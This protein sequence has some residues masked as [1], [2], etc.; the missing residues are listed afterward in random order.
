MTTIGVTGHRTFPDAKAVGRGVDRALKKIQKVFAGPFQ[1]CSCLAPGADQMV[2]ERAMYLLKARL[3]VPL[4]L[5]LPEYLLEFAPAPAL[6]LQTLLEQAAEVIH[7]PPQRTRSAAY[8]AAGQMMLGRIDVL[9]TIWDGLPA[10]G[11]G[12]TGEIAAQARLAGIPLAWIKTPDR[13]F[14]PGDQM[15]EGVPV[16]YEGFDLP[17]SQ[18]AERLGQ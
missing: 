8:E 10:H 1:I 16:W 18:I 11:A 12:G 14:D 5:P 7:I 4:P 3:V 17:A 13:L 9:V 2:A 15:R 6:R